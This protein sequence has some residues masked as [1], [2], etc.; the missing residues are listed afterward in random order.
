MKTEPER[1]PDEVLLD[2]LLRDEEWQAASTAMKSRALATFQARHR[3]RRLA[4]WGLGAG[5]CA[6]VLAGATY[7][8]GHTPVSRPTALSYPEAPK[9]VNATR[10]LTDEEL[11]ASF[12]KGSCFLAEVDGKKELIFVD[13][14]V[15]R[16]YMAR[17]QRARQ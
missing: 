10:Y 4:R 3:A 11:L 12:P 13:P 8:S 2:A 7:W 14:N 1:G 16:E 6:A 15:E 9:R 5:V 17:P